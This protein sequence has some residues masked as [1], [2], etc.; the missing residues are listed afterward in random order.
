MAQSAVFSE[1]GSIKRTM[2]VGGNHPSGVF[3]TN[4]PELVYIVKG[5]EVVFKVYTINYQ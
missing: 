5:N 3:Q 2:D 4:L 1:H